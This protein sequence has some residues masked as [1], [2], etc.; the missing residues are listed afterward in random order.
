MRADAE[1]DA[2]I[3]SASSAVSSEYV[4]VPLM[5]SQRI[6]IVVPAIEGGGAEVVAGKWAEALEHLGHQ[7]DLITTHRSAPAQSSDLSVVP[8]DPPKPGVVAAVRALRTKLEVGR[9]DTV[10]SILT[11]SNLL[12]L[13]STFLMR[14]SRPRIVI[15]EHTLHSHRRAEYGWRMRGQQWLA[16]RLY[17]YADGWIAPSHAVAAE[18]TT[19]YHLDNK[20]MWVIPNPV[21]FDP[22]AQ[23][24]DSYKRPKDG[25]LRLVF[26]G[27]LLSPKRPELVL[28]IA[29]HLTTSWGES[30][31]VDFIGDGEL[32]Q[33]LS[34]QASNCPF[35]VNFHGWVDQ[36][37]K[38]CG[39]GSVLVVPSPIEGFGNVLIEAASVGIPAVV[40]SRCLGAAD[41]CIPGVTGQLIVDDTV[42]S[43][44]AA[45][46]NAAFT[47]TTDI[48]AWIE[49]FSIAGAAE[50]L[51][52]AIG[53]SADGMSPAPQVGNEPTRTVAGGMTK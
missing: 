23:D 53:G 44:S 12:C 5:S 20:K 1:K 26:V 49:R 13:C 18:M 25:P 21:A 11:F 33:E 50:R 40:S 31:V 32:R 14:R 22:L 3:S 27:R 8:L 30:V 29:K 17:R 43:F 47:Q 37:H 42:P 4:E 24:P 52:L 38:C 35:P 48:Q 19:A 34:A 10:V 41:A 2:A 28:E 15:S 36:W 16:S 51:H 39:P 45:V 46:R 9:Y 6:A 7:V